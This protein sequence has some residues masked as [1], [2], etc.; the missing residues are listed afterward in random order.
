M[1]AV[2]LSGNREVFPMATYGVTAPQDTEADVIELMGLPR[3]GGYGTLIAMFDRLE[4]GEALLVVDNRN[5]TWILKLLREVRADV[6]D[7]ARSHAFEKP[8][9][10]FLYLAKE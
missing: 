7:R 4:S 6:L 2:P 3:R 1:E 10:Y 8:E 5:L 9:N